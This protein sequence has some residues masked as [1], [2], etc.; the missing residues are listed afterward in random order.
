MPRNTFLPPEAPFIKN[1]TVDIYVCEGLCSQHLKKSLHAWGSE[2]SSQRT[3]GRFE[4]TCLLLMRA[5]AGLGLVNVLSF[6]NYQ[7]ATCS[8]TC[9]RAVL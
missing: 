9:L 1:E 8:C 2:L 4:G 6:M 7:Y 5:L 3:H